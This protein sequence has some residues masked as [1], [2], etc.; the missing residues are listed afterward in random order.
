MNILIIEDDLLL[1]DHIFHTFETRII[2]NRIRVL[3]SFAQFTR[4]LH[5]ISAYD[6]ILTD[7]Q[8]SDD[9]RELNGYKVIE[10]VR[11][12]TPDTPIIVI[13]CRGEIEVLR[14]AFDLWA[15]DYIIKPLRLKELELRVMNWFRQYQFSGI[16]FSEKSYTIGSLEY[17]LDKNEFFKYGSKIHLTKMN[18][19]ILSLFFSHAWKILTDEFL[20]EKIWWDRTNIVE[21]NL[22][23]TIMRLKKSLEP[24][25]IADWISNIRWEWYILIAR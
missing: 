11:E 22:R 15:S 16:R 21:R 14:K 18:R 1:A 10:L 9:T 12:R 5:L 13:S 6:I 8:L 19:Y 24:Y 7:L 2:S 23:V 4:E 3:H 17:N 25:G 20:R